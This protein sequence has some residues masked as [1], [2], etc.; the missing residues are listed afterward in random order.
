M[1]AKRLGRLYIALLHYP[2][3][4]KKG[5]AVGTAVVNL[6][7]HDIARTARTYCVDRFYIV[8]PFQSQFEFIRRV[9]QHWG[10]EYG[11]THNPTRTDALQLERTVHDYD[12]MLDEIR[13]DNPGMRIETIGT[14]RQA[15]QGRIG[16]SELS[17]RI[18][19]EQTAFLLLFGTGHGIASPVR[20][21][22][23][24]FLPPIRG[25]GEYNHL[26]VRSAAA[27]VLDRLLAEPERRQ[28]P[29]DDRITRQPTF[30]GK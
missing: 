21:R 8:T 16:Y 5:D 2:V 4:N 9:I 23:D 20:E 30:A 14:S 6:S 1:T 15:G 7:I 17:E 12:A 22:I 13:E 18:S 26:P 25:V 28:R 27:I 19:T 29:Q 11:L 10:S 3:L 24:R